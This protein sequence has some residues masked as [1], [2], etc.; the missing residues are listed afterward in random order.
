MRRLFYMEVHIT[1]NAC[2]VSFFAFVYLN[3]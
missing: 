1:V 2:A 3:R